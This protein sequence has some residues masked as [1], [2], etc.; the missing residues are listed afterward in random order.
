MVVLDGIHRLH[1][2]TTTVLQRLAQDREV[3][4]SDGTQ[5]LPPAKFDALQARLGLTA[6]EL[7]EQGASCESLGCRV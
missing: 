7:K 5:L 6:D 2:S 3:T 1:P 4:L